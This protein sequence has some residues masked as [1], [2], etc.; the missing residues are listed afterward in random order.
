MKAL[1]LSINPEHV[2]NILNETKKFEFR[3]IRCKCSVD[4]LVIY[5]T[6]PVKMVVGEAHIVRIIENSPEKIWNETKDGAGI[7]KGFFD[8]Y[9]SG[10]STAV[11]Y[12]LGDV[13]RYSEPKLISDYGLRCPPQSFSYVEF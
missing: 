3:K 10:R 1:L 5:C 2:E 13:T 9:Y 7:S 12:E 6:A 11:A 8:K 4:L